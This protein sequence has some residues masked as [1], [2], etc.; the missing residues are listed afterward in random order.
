MVP[1]VGSLATAA[2]ELWFSLPSL[3]RDTIS[4]RGHSLGLDILLAKLPAFLLNTKISFPL[5]L[6]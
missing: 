4:Q 1:A 2:Q 3:H 6:K 5:R